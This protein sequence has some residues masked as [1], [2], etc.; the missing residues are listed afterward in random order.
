MRPATLGAILLSSACCWL[1]LEDAARAQPAGR[2]FGSPHH[3]APKGGPKKAG[4]HDYGQFDHGRRFDFPRNR[5][6]T[7]VRSFW[8]Q[9]P[10]PYH[11][12]YY[13]REYGGSYDPYFGNLY[14]PPA[15]Y[16]PVFPYQ[17]STPPPG[18]WPYEQSVPVPHS[19][20]P[21]AQ[22]YSYGGAYYW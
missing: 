7:S 6:A 22:P 12:D 15:V 9:R 3:N 11:L 20:A 17:G 21:L 4:K 18:A 16:A 5:P 19:A 13:R 8:F 2:G 1:V 10:Y 14:G